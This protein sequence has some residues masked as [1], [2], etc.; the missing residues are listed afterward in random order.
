MSPWNSFTCWK[1][2]YE[3]VLY[4]DLLISVCHALVSKIIFISLIWDF[5]EHFNHFLIIP[6]F[7]FLFCSIH[8]DFNDL[9]Y[10][11]IVDTLEAEY[12][13]SPNRENLIM[14]KTIFPPFWNYSP[15]KTLPLFP[16]LPV[17]IDPELTTKP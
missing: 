12:R 5:L 15:A 2:M 16:F 13:S 14:K 3:W 9:S 8:T 10:F 6:K 7:F 17:K 1:S 11:S 4:S